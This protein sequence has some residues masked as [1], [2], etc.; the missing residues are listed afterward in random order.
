MFSEFVDCFGPT[1][2]AKCRL[3]ISA[4]L[5]I[6]ECKLTDGL[7]SVHDRSRI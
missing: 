3:A 6:K 7:T 2:T 1:E 4:V 5:A